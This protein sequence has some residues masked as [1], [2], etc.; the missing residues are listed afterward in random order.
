MKI[1]IG[2]AFGETILA[3]FIKTKISIV[4]ALEISYLP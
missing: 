1:L 2:M 4:F 3:S